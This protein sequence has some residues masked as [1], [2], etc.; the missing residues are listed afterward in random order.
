MDFFSALEHARISIIN[1]PDPHLRRE[2]RATGKKRSW[3]HGS[4]TTKRYKGV[5]DHHVSSIDIDEPTCAS[6]DLQQLVTQP[7]HPSVSGRHRSQLPSSLI[8]SHA[9]PT[10]SGD[11]DQ[12]QGGPG[13]SDCN[14]AVN[15]AQSLRDG[16]QPMIISGSK[17]V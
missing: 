2:S 6:I 17:E 3:K 11:P 12:A 14:S 15:V 8:L 4:G 7:L 13:M 1:Q 10:S 16:I 9:F 5:D